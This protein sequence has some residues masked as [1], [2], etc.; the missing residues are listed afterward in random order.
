L[1]F[2]SFFNPRAPTHV[3]GLLPLLYRYLHEHIRRV[4]LLLLLLLL[5]LVLLSVGGVRLGD[6]FIRHSTR[7]M[8]SCRYRYNNGSSPRTSVG[9]LGLKKEE[10]KSKKQ[11]IPGT[12]YRPREAEKHQAC[13]HL[14]I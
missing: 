13:A 11:K 7:L 5:L 1:L 12:W 2:A 9:A 10:A 14:Y 6:Y 4:L 3:R 8:C